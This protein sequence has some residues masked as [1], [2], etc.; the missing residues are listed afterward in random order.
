[1]FK[2]LAAE[3]LGISEI[4]VIVSPADYD[5]V[6]ADDYLF[7]EDG[8]KIFFLIK[9]K[10]DEYCF[11]NLG[12]IHVDGDSAVSSKR[13]IKRYEYAH[14]RIGYV[15]IET[16]GTLDMD[17]E[18]K[19]SIGDA[20]F[21]IDIKKTFIEQLKDIY[22]A[23]IAIGK[24]Q[25]Q[26]AMGRENAVRALDALSGMLKLGNLAGEGAVVSH[27]NAVL[28]GLN[29]ATLEKHLTRDYSKVFERYIH[30]GAAPPPLPR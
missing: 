3:A 18:L 17:I 19:F 27:Y 24:Q 28:D 20:A 11:T 12:L 25:H 9:S 13:S 6:D 30:N 1:M 8:E 15:M 29:A 23:L 2:K 26:D 4:G 5:K 16:A 14:Q 7:H 22:K 10:K 21:N